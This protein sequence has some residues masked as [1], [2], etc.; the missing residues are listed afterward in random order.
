MN[1][2]VDGNVGLPVRL[3]DPIEAR[4]AS[5]GFASFRGRDVLIDPALLDSA[6]RLAAE[7]QQLPPDPY[8]RDG[9][10][11]RRYGV[12]YLVTPTDELLATRL[13]HYC[14]SVTLNRVDGG[15]VREFA[16]LTDE[17]RSSPFLHGLIRLDFTRS[18][19]DAGNLLYQVG[20]H[21]IR[22]SPRGDAPAFSHALHK[23][24]EA[25]TYSHLV[26]RENVRGGVGM[27]AGN[28]RQ[29]VWEGLQEK[30]LDSFAVVDRRVYHAVTPVERLDPARDAWR[31]VLLI[32]FTPVLPVSVE[33]KSHQAEVYT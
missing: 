4:M 12:F 15:V 31:D 20:V 27:V 13:S 21:L 24:G 5:E 3:C 28:D 10:W 18:G 17:L 8:S 32:D 30:F 7:F 11:S 25:V 26:A 19:L 2:T 22:Q 29:V 9:S 14:Q 1:L 23:D 16:P 6:A 33:P